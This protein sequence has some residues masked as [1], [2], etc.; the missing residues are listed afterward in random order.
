MVNTTRSVGGGGHHVISGHP[1]LNLNMTRLKIEYTPVAH[2]NFDWIREVQLNVRLV[3]KKLKNHCLKTK[4][5]VS[6]SAHPGE[7][8]NDEPLLPAVVGD[9]GQADRLAAP[10]PP[11]QHISEQTDISLGPWKAFM[12]WLFTYIRGPEQCPTTITEKSGTGGRFSLAHEWRKKT[13]RHPAYSS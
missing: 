5:Q 13:R 3:H 11:V 9:V 1:S 8:D 2:L 7:G 6:L 4:W 12:S 10:L